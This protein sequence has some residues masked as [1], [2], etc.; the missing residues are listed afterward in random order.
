MLLASYVL[1]RSEP[2]HVLYD[3]FHVLSAGASGVYT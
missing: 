1:V 2:S 3:T